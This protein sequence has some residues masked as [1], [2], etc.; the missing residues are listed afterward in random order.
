MSLTGEFVTK[1]TSY[2]MVYEPDPAFYLYFQICN[3]K[4]PVYNKYFVRRHLYNQYGDLIRA[5]IIKLSE[6]ELR[7]LFKML[8]PFQ[9]KIIGYYDFTLVDFPTPGEVLV[10]QSDILNNDYNMSGYRPI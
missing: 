3:T 6:N 10:A 8:K 7:K 4:N 9:Y 1:K 5:S 2:N